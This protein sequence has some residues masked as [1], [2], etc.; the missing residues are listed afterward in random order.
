MNVLNSHIQA[1][2]TMNNFPHAVLLPY[3][4]SHRMNIDG[5]DGADVLI[6]CN[7][8]MNVCAYYY[9]LLYHYLHYSKYI[10]ILGIF[11]CNPYHNENTYHLVHLLVGLSVRMYLMIDIHLQILQMGHRCFLLPLQQQHDPS[12]KLL[13]LLLQH[14]SLCF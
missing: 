3:I 9:R 5:I 1:D 14:N 12:N 11:R 10:C 2:N 7:M 8:T 13:L 6:H 4:L